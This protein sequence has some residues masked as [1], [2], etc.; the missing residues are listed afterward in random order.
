VGVWAGVNEVGLFRRRF[1]S[2]AIHSLVVVIAISLPFAD[3][4]TAPF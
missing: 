1:E 2:V 4:Q 3:S